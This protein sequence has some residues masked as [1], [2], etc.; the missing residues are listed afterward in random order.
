MTTALTAS[1][2]PLAAE[3]THPFRE[4]TA[5]SDDPGVAALTGTAFHAL[6]HA[7]LAGLPAPDPMPG[8]DDEAARAMFEAWKAW[9]PTFRGSL[10]WHAETPVAF[11]LDT[12]AGRFLP[13]SGHR[14]YSAARRSE[15]PG[16]A[17]A[18]AYEPAHDTLHVLDWKTGHPDYL[19]PADDSKQLVALALAL[20]RNPELDPVRVVFVYMVHVAPEGVRVDRA[21]LEDLDLDAAEADLRDVVA[22]IADER[23]PRPGPHCRYCP[24]RAGCP[25][26]ER[27]LVPFVEE[28]PASAIAS[29]L[30][31]DEL[32]VDRIAL[33]HRALPMIEELAKKARERIKA[34]AR[35][36]GGRIPLGN[37]K[38]LKLISMR[39]EGLSK[40]SINEALGEAEAHAVLER[41]RAAGAF[42]HSTY[43]QLREVK[44]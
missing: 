43:D 40:D 2:L 32:T 21:A 12:G 24:A 20:A 28:T 8:A 13:A 39:R 33:A 3:C 30:R 31:G 26:T 23:A 34:H 29:I 36:L 11:D 16:T 38:A 41:L 7:E 15:I 42:T 10:W 6:V 44:A 19:D 35:Q 17:D 1:R 22:G 27:S 4:G 37:G 9:W 18:I 25:E 14:D 5:T